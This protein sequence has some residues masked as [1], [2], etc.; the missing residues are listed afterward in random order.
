MD[1]R[2]PFQRASSL[3]PRELWTALGGS[4][5][6]PRIA[7]AS[8]GPLLVLGCARHVWQDLAALGPWHGDT[9]A[10]NDIGT[11]WAQPLTHW[12]SL[13]PKLLP[14]W[15]A[16]RATRYEASNAPRPFTHSHRQREGIDHAWPPG[17]VGGG[18]GM[19]AALVGLMLG[20]EHVI[21]AG[22]PMD[23]SGH[24]YDPPE[25]RNPGPLRANHQEAWLKAADLFAGRVKSLSG[26]TRR[27]LGAPAIG[28][29][30]AGLEIIAAVARLE[31]GLPAG[32][33]P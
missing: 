10:I 13:Y 18:G 21:L 6:P 2:R 3:T 28:P 14:A 22:V 27:L 9:M 23:G 12:L 20:Y 8:T 25:F 30:V 1:A 26:N 4:A 11:H 19:A 32:G 31:A 24:Y 15:A 33:G 5:E 7:G 29:R 17:I 16:I